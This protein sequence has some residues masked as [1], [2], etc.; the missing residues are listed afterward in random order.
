MSAL[1]LLPPQVEPPRPRMLQPVPPAPE[2]EPPKPAAKAPEPETDVA[3]RAKMTVGL[4]QQV[5]N[6]RTGE[7]AAPPPTEHA[8]TE[9]PRARGPEEP[10]PKGPAKPPESE[11]HKAAAPK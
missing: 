1:E 3:A 11:E 9:E 8:P 5:G 4:Q 10:N 7:M 2:V 6:A